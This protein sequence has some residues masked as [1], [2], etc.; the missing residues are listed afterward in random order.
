MAPNQNPHR[1]LKLLLIAVG[2]GL[3]GLAAATVALKLLLPPEKIKTRIAGEAGRVL[4]RQIRIK[5]VSVGLIQGLRVEGVEVSEK[6]D[7]K[8]GTFASVG[9][10]DFKVQLMPLLSKRVVIDRVVVAEPSAR[11]VK[12]KDGSFNFSDLVAPEAANSKP[13]NAKAKDAGKAAPL[14]LPFLLD[15]KKARVSGGRIVYADP[16]A[17][18]EF[19]VSGLDLSADGFSL[20]RPFRACFSLALDGRSGSMRLGGKAA[21]EA[22]FD[23][24]RMLKAAP[25]SLPIGISGLTSDVSLSV[26]DPSSGLDARLTDLSASIDEARLDAPFDAAASLG[27]D[28]KTAARRVQGKASLKARFDVSRAAEGIAS[29]DVKSAVLEAAGIKA[30][31]AMRF[32]LDPKQVSL[33]GI[34]GNL[35]G[36]RLTGLLKARN[37]AASPDVRFEAELTAL[38]LEP[39]LAANE[40]TSLEPP[41]KAVK[42]TPPKTADKAADKTAEGRTKGNP[43][44]S[45]AA[46]SSPPMSTSGFIK[47]GEV[48][49]PFASA[50]D[51]SLDWDLKGITPTLESLAGSAAM[52]VAGGHFSALDSLASRSKALKVLTL[53]F[54]VIQ[55][56]G[57]LPIINKVLPDFSTVNFSEIVGDYAFEKGVMTL[58]RCSLRSSVANVDA[59]GTADLPK[60]TL[61]VKILSQVGKL[62][63]IGIDV[64]GTFNDP[65]TRL[66]ASTLLTQPVG[67]AVEPAR[68]L[69]EGLFKRKK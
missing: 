52:K 53:P 34:S 22:S 66:Q 8:A 5:D 64:T 9:S 3:A 55:K 39:L 33:T 60:E 32:S 68:K 65:K 29:A 35:L 50:K 31:L 56:I 69:I 42:K 15:V 45:A 30:D 62:A 25:G 54:V 28:A 58:R 7:F 51:I 38:E 41:G 40:A 17:A 11:I 36:G 61:A 13:A 21:G 1:L 10:F 14:A 12:N 47:V 43:S 24:S 6:P 27:F 63:P 46:S 19:T 4:G 49:H 26:Q 23:L 18:Q 20:E 67:R 48:R 44:A 37:Y 57:R 16:A 2:A 59:T